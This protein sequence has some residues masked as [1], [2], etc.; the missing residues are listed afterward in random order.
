V[1][2]GPCIR[3]VCGREDVMGN[4]EFDC[5][6]VLK[7]TELMRQFIECMKEIPAMTVQPCLDLPW[8]FPIF[9]GAPP[10]LPMSIDH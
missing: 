3:D 9:R 2:A 8:A 10:W 7:H 4:R 6:F 1:K 5:V